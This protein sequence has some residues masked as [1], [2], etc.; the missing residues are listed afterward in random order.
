MYSS[1]V[2]QKLFLSKI[3]FG[4][5]TFLRH[6]FMRLG[7]KCLITKYNAF[8]PYMLHGVYYWKDRERR[9][10]VCAIPGGGVSAS[11]HGTARA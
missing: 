9:S 7:S 1:C 5:Q 11:N 8:L 4:Y 2:Y 3:V 6:S 10:A